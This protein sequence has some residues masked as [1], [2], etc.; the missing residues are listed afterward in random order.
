MMTATIPFK[1][2]SI[3]ESQTRTFSPLRTL[4]LEIFFFPP[5]KRLHEVM[6]DAIVPSFYPLLCFC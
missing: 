4:I 6:N 5:E 1:S 2:Y 3:L